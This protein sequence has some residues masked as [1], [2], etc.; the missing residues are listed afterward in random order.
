MKKVK[1][2]FKYVLVILLIMTVVFVFLANRNL[3]GIYGGH[4]KQVDYK[5]FNPQ[6]A[7]IVINNVNVLSPEGEKFIAGR[8]VL[9]E[10]GTIVSIDSVPKVSNEATIINGEGKYLIPGLI[11]SHVHLFKSSN[12][13]LLYVANGVTQIREMIGESEHLIWR[14]Q[15]KEGRIG[16]DMFVASPRLG[17]FGFFEGLFMSWSQGYV[18]IQNAKDAEKMAKKFQQNGYDAIKIYSQ[19]NKESYRSLCKTGDSL[20]MKVVGH[21]PWSVDLLEVFTNKQ[22]EIAHLEEVM[23]ALNREFDFYDDNEH[24]KFLAFV[25][26]RC[27]EIAQDLIDNNISVGTTLWL[28]QSFVKQKFEL[29]NVLKSVALEYENPGISEWDKKIP[30]G[31]GW[32]PEVNR[33]R[34]HDNLNAEQA[35]GH[36]KWWETY[37]KACEVALKTLSNKGVEIMAGTDAN[38][39]PTVPGFSLHDELASLANAGM[40]PSQVL[41][42]ATSTPAHWLNTNTGK[43]TQG[44]TANLVLL[45][46][47][48]LSDINNTRT[49][50]AV[51][52]KGRLLDRAF[53]NNMLASVKEANNSSRKIDIKQW[54]NK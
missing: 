21:I 11:D 15:I 7:S 22:H 28:T 51:I 35:A 54:L 29:D 6:N 36:K 1:K 4:T 52:L 24:E 43:I 46:K 9:I 34:I 38:L 20:G 48:P 49:I 5:Q 44:S 31:L 32:L 26:K 30:G 53:L 41:Q 27:N 3:I 16:P 17:S 14:Q 37:A 10:N 39:P 25:E 33:Y 19:L 50:N 47:D 42:S 23:N 13:L 2:V 18:N 45:D 8:N 40:S 12:D